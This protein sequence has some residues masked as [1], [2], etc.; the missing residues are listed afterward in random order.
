MAMAGRVANCMLVLRCNRFARHNTHISACSE[1]N[2]AHTQRMPDVA[3]KVSD[4]RQRGRA[5]GVANYSLDVDT[6]CYFTSIKCAASARVWHLSHY[7]NFVSVNMLL[8]ALVHCQSIWQVPEPRNFLN[9]FAACCHC[10][11]K[12][13]CCL[14]LQTSLYSCCSI[15]CHPLT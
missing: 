4:C 7:A 14:Q 11:Y 10:V 8:K 6:K 15:G 13:F 12:Y 2:V 3:P 1:V 5:M 9:A